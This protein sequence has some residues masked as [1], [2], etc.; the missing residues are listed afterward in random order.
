[1]PL[2]QLT[3][4]GIVSMALVVFLG[5][6]ITTST[7]YWLQQYDYVAKVNHLPIRTASYQRHLI[8]TQQMFASAQ[9]TE[10]MLQQL[11]LNQLIDRALFLEAARVQNLTIPHTD[12]EQEWQSLL[13]MQY[14][15]DTERMLRVLHSTRHSEATFREEL[16]Q[17]LLSRR[18]QEILT[19]DISLTEEEL[20]KYYQENIQ[21]Y[22]LP[23]RI[24]VQHILLH[25]DEKDPESVAKTHQKALDILKQLQ[26]GGDFSDLARQHSDDS[27]SNEE[28]GQLAPFAKSEMVEAFEKAA[29]PLKPGEIAPRPIQTEFGWHLIKRGQ[30]LAAGPRDFESARPIFEA[31][32]LEQKKQTFLQNW[33]AQERQKQI[34]EIHPAYQQTHVNPDP[35]QSP[36]QP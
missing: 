5:G 28:G 7:H 19:E 24:E 35:S 4:R 15:N 2:K 14:G 21:D 32:L 34:I 3:Q 9:A 11:T 31:R 29:W 17:R 1:M 20:K 23:E 36:D 27:S 16:K 8:Q 25:L 12:V 6:G 33:L 26:Q 13:Q 30:T 10:A 18:I 22:Q